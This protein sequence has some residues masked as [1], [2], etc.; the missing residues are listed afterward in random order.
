MI[1]YS[2]N[3][4]T[5]GQFFTKAKKTVSHSFTDDEKVKVAD[6]VATKLN[7]TSSS[8][9]HVNKM[10]KKAKRTVLDERKNV[11]KKKFTE[12]KASANN[13]N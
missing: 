12:Y 6:I 1:C 13:T 7:D 11:L 3:C 2:A 9:K 4:Q 10:V 8:L 5:S